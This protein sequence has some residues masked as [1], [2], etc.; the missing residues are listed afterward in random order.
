MRFRADDALVCWHRF[1]LAHF[2]ANDPDHDPDEF[3][4]ESAWAYIEHRRHTEAARAQGI[5][6]HLPA[7]MQAVIAERS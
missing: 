5:F 4:H 2:C 6:D 7:E 1:P 3:I